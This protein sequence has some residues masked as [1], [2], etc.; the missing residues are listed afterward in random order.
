MTRDQTTVLENSAGPGAGRARSAAVLFLGA[1]LSL[2]LLLAA[3]LGTRPALAVPAFAVQTG[4]P[5]AN[6]HIGSFGP[7]L[8]PQGRDFKLHGYVASDGKDHGLPLAWVT[9]TSFTHTAVSHPGGAAPGFRQNDNIAL[10]SA[11]AY[12]T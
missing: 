8:T 3:A 12:Y 1:G 9:E 11:A 6:C 5:C 2:L 7:H 10:D 4:Q